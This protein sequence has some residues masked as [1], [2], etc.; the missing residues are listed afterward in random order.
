MIATRRRLRADL[1]CSADVTSPIEK[2]VRAT[3]TKMSRAKMSFKDPG[4]GL[5]QSIGITHTA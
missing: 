3:V 5:A 4:I 1:T 2:A